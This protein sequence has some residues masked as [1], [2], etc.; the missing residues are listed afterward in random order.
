MK[1]PV[2][3]GKFKL[4]LPELGEGFGKGFGEGFGEGLGEGGWDD[5]QLDGRH[6]QGKF[7]IQLTVSI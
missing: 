7:G 1:L 4:N 2:F 3:L 5:E 6:G